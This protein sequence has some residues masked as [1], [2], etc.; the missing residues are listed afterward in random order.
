MDTQLEDLNA[1]VEYQHR[2]DTDYDFAFTLPFKVKDLSSLILE[3]KLI[4]RIR[5][6]FDWFVEAQDLDTKDGV[7]LGTL[8][9]LPLEIRQR[10]YRIAINNHYSDFVKKYSPSYVYGPRLYDPVEKVQAKLSKWIL[11]YE[12]SSAIGGVV[13]YLNV[14][15]LKAYHRGGFRRYC[16]S[17][18]LW[19]SDFPD[20][21][22]AL[23]Y[24]SPTI[25]DEFDQI[26]LSETTF[27]FSCAGAF[28]AFLSQLSPYQQSQ[29]RHMIFKL[30]CFCQCKK[31][32]GLYCDKCDSWFSVFEQ[33]SSVSVQ[34]LTSVHFELGK[35]AYFCP[36]KKGQPRR[37]KK[38]EEVAEFLGFLSHKLARIAPKAKVSL[39]KKSSFVEDELAALKSILGP[40]VAMEI[41]DVDGSV[42]MAEAPP[43]REAV[44][45]KIDPVLS[46]PIH[47][48]DDFWDFS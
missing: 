7:R 27:T 23:R 29:L 40:V 31:P 36:W 4:E 41:V 5:D 6:C 42:P 19:D 20:I 10:I 32:K 2:Y 30:F 45:R 48:E 12:P 35:Y 16:K 14:F 3:T 15:D 47:S 28:R 24:T 9:Y 11:H 25:R 22:P 13:P 44:E 17:D 26:Y 1:G 34:S 21:Q 33:I 38:L 46:D 37:I 43:T 39:G 8:R 18:R